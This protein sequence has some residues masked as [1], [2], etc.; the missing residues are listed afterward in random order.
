MRDAQT[1]DGSKDEIKSYVNAIDIK[2]NDI[3][4]VQREFSQPNQ[5]S[6]TILSPWLLSN[7]ILMKKKELFEIKQRP[8]SFALLFS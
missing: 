8:A 6:Y 3:R 2:I 4:L 5:L 7:A 1:N